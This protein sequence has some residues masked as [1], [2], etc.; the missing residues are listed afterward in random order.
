MFSTDVIASM[1]KYGN[2]LAES[3]M[4]KA[5]KLCKEVHDV[6]TFVILRVCEG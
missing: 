4:E 6:G 1:E 2:E 3:V 5:K